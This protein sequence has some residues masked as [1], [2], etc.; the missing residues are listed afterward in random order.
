MAQLSLSN[1][2][3]E[4]LLAIVEQID[5]HESLCNLSSTNRRFQGLAEPFI[6][7]KLLVLNGSHADGIAYA[8]RSRT[9]RLSN[10]QTLAIH[11]TNEVEIGIRKLDP[12]VRIMTKLRHLTIESPCPNNSEW[13]RT[14]EFTG[15]TKIDYWTLLGDSI[16]QS[17]PDRPL[18]MLQSLTLHGHGKGDRKF[19]L[20]RA[21]N[22]FLHPTLRHITISCV[23]FEAGSGIIRIEDLPPN[24]LRSTPLQSL[25]LIE[26]NIY[27]DLLEIALSLP[28]SLKELNL[29]ERL[30]AWNDCYPV[31]T[32][33]TT[34]HPRLLDAL[35]NQKDSLER[36][37]HISGT[38][39]QNST[40]NLPSSTTPKLHV[41]EKL[42]YLEVDN[43]SHL[44]DHI[45]PET[46]ITT[47]K[48]TDAVRAASLGHLFLPS[49]IYFTDFF[50]RGHAV[51]SRCTKPINI[52]MVF[53]A[54]SRS[55]EILPNLRHYFSM[56]LHRD[57]V[58]GFV[59]T[60]KTR[61]AR[62]RIFM[63]RF[64]GGAT[65]IRPFMYGEERPIEEVVFDS[66]VGRFF[67]AE[68]DRGGEGEERGGGDGSEE[69]IGF[70]YMGPLPFLG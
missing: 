61:G 52:D 12:L 6:W 45:D 43:R 54:Q 9:E 8:L 30:Y 26:C 25:T 5:C 33:P 24:A 15:W 69:E 14:D 39:T 65:F 38:Y 22:V 57:V 70:E 35:L 2:V 66:E 29:G 67:G 4:L 31:A 51:A 55:E 17:I 10:I 36:L 64:A 13:I 7:R 32:Q 58:Y 28:K 50:Q 62:L 53:T 18:Q 46:H 20:G 21:M 59:K 49:F 48:I 11:Y 40:T 16:D 68:Y 3:D 34:T 56:K 1:F 47:L 60:M 19:D 63:E 41:M 37:S 42:H 23:N 27:L 44:L